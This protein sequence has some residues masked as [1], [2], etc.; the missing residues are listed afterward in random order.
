LG[1]G[2]QLLHNGGG[3]VPLHEPWGSPAMTDADLPRRRWYQFRLRTLLIVMVLCAVPMAWLSYKLQPARRE[4][5]AVEW[6]IQQEGTINVYPILG[7][8][9]LIGSWDEWMDQWFG[10]SAH[11]VS[12]FDQEIED[13]SPLQDI[14][15]LRTLH[16]IDSAVEDLAPLAQLENLQQ[17]QINDTLVSEAQFQMLQKSLPN[18]EIVR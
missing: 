18:C 7:E 4:R 13:L 8:Q 15:N 11:R 3:V 12:F 2:H 6:V 1:E 5:V 17:L 10:M 16:L 14:N 9:V